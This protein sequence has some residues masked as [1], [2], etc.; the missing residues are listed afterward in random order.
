MAEYR[1][2]GTWHSRPQWSTVGPGGWH[3]SL[4]LLPGPNI[5][6]WRLHI[7]NTMSILVEQLF[8]ASP[9]RE[10]NLIQVFLPGWKWILVWLYLSSHFECVIS[11]SPPIHSCLK[12]TTWSSRILL[13]TLGA[14]TPSSERAQSLLPF[15][16]RTQARPGPPTANSPTHTQIHSTLLQKELIFHGKEAYEPFSWNWKEAE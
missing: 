12:L 6:D 8:F 14:A 1:K 9:V 16:L 11:D 5:S 3:Q 4:S 13:H 15:Q 10:G 7:V 2:Y